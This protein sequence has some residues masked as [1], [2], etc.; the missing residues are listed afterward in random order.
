M[1][2]QLADRFG[3]RQLGRHIARSGAR[4][5]AF[6]AERLPGRFEAEGA[7][8]RRAPREDLRREPFHPLRHAADLF[9]QAQQHQPVGFRQFAQAQV[10]HAG[11]H[12]PDRDH[13]VG[14]ARIDQDLRRRD[15][16]TA[17]HYVERV[18]DGGD[19]QLRTG[20]G[21]AHIQPRQQRHGLR[22]HRRAIHQ[23]QIAQRPARPAA[24]FIE[25]AAFQHAEARPFGIGA[26]FAPHRVAIGQDRDRQ[27]AAGTIVNRLVSEILHRISPF[28]LQ[29]QK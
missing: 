11:Q 24:E 28:K 26:H 23:H 9:G 5:I 6:A 15:G 18:H 21:R 12:A 19:D 25:A 20:L 7:A 4:F 27:L 17:E 2:D 13:P 1:V 14:A 8:V 22:I 10:R 29:E 3:G 16:E